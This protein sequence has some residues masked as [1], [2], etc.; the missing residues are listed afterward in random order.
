[1]KKDV[2]SIVIPIYNG[3]KYLKDCFEHLL[4]QTYRK[5]EVIVVDDG[6]TD[7]TKQQLIKYKKTFEDNNIEFIFLQ[8]NN[9][10]QAAAI[11]NALKY[12]NGE[13]LV[14]Q[15]C[16]DYYEENAIENLVEYLRKHKN[17]D[18]V[19]GES[20]YRDEDDLNNIIFEGK[21][22][23]P[24]LTKIFDL[25]VFETDAYNYPGIFMVRMNFFDKC[26]KNRTIYVSRAGQ[27]WQL[28]L[29]LAYY[30]KC[31]YLNKVVYN[32]RVCKNSHSHIVS[33]K[34]EKLLRCDEH[35]DI[36]MHVLNEL[37]MNSYTLFKYKIM[38][39][40]KYLKK[41][42]RIRLSEIKKLVGGFYA[43]NI[44]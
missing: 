17:I 20:L 30:G 44:K 36:L 39:E 8:Q 26:I 21:S 19:R 37:K 18:F 33:T 13:F 6:S 24:N 35:K 40:I 4:K 7:G 29:P 22:K 28:I 11:N 43:K 42:T 10:G 5:L 23:Y 25:Y 34:K 31:G 12:V 9:K 32:Y 15:D 14:W 41:K 2:V 1:M 38:I 16:D 3:E 27:N